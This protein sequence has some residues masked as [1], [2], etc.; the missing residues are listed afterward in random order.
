MRPAAERK[1][2]AK[3]HDDGDLCVVHAATA[4]AGKQKGLEE[5]TSEQATEI[6]AARRAKTPA[7]EPTP[8]TTI[9]VNTEGADIAAQD[10][11]AREEINRLQGVVGQLAGALDSLQGAMGDELKKQQ[12]FTDLRFETVAA[13]T[14]P[15]PS[16]AKYPKLAGVLHLDESQDGDAEAWQAAIQ[17]Y[18]EGQ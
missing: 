6:S 13:E 9:M 18:K 1:F 16:V 3:V 10:P 2:Y 5:I 11:E 12:W 14:D 15:A 17:A 8:P 4:W 7:P